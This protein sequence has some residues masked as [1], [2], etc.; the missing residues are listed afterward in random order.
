M[1]KHSR[2]K[3][4]DRDIRAEAQ[5]IASMQKID[6]QTK[7]QTKLIA[8]GIQKGIEHYLRQSSEKS[9]DLDRRTKALKKKES[10]AEVSSVEIEKVVYRHSIYPWVGLV[11]SWLFFIGFVLFKLKM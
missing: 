11:V 5:K 8:K 6:G 9:R 1:A 10:N 4:E 3:K 7:E 2:S